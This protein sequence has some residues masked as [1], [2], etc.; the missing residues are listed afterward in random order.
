MD[1]IVS[2]AFWL[3]SIYG[4]AS[5]PGWPGSPVACTK[6]HL[7]SGQ[8]FNRK[9]QKIKTKVAVPATLDLSDPGMGWDGDNLF[10]S[11]EWSGE[12]LESWSASGQ[13]VY[14]MPKGAKRMTM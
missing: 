11:S 5:R 4:T 8:G 7:S 14:A 6:S 13:F 3:L 12:R 1:H 9:L 10:V 2:A